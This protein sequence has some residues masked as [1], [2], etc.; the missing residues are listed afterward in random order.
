VSVGIA[1]GAFEEGT[2]FLQEKARPWVYAGVEEARH[3]PHLLKL[4]GELATSLHAAEALL[5]RAAETVE[6][7][8]REL[9]STNVRH[10]RLAIGEA[11]A[12]G[13]E[14]AIRIGTEI[15]VLGGTSSTAAKHNLD[16]HWRNAVTHSTHDPA[17]WLYFHIGNAEVNNIAPPSSGKI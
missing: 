1:G 5:A 14:V 6:V 10:A 8:R 15:F 3:E 11:K 13:T 4:E 2:A 7:A 12:L 9:T 17:R 16:R